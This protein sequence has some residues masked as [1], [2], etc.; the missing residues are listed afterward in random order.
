M[1]G[2]AINWNPDPETPRPRIIAL[3]L[4]DT[5]H[6]IL[7]FSS[8][9]FLCSYYSCSNY[10]LSFPID[11]SCAAE[12]RVFSHSRQV[13]HR[14]VRGAIFS[15]SSCDS[16]RNSREIAQPSRLVSALRR[17]E[18][19]RGYTG[20]QNISLSLCTSD[21]PPEAPNFRLSHRCDEAKRSLNISTFIIARGRAEER[22]DLT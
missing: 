16:S 12:V 15:L 11:Q 4:L 8:L 21:C 13:C 20:G 17:S 7:L 22:L 9:S 6:L 5:D 19:G 18:Q 2:V 10:S 3:L 1:S 14:E